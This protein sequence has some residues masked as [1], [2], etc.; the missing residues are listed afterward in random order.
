MLSGIN[1]KFRY[2]LNNIT[3][4]ENFKLNSEDNLENI[5]NKYNQF[6]LPKNDQNQ[7]TFY[8]LKKN[9]KLPLDKNIKTKELNLKEGDSILVSFEP[10]NST[11]S[12]IP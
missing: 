3:H 5:F 10:N 4:I 1:V 12:T 2:T 7:I 8:L 6:K 9:E 11:I